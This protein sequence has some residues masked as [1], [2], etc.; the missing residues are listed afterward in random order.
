MP[1]PNPVIVVPIVIPNPA[2]TVP[3]VIVPEITVVTVSVVVEID[4]VNS[5]PAIVEI[6]KSVSFIIECT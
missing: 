4:P 5:P 2:I 3:T 6:L 1:V